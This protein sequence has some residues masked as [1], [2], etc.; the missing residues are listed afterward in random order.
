MGNESFFLASPKLPDEFEQYYQFRW[1]QLRKP[2]SF[3]LG[4]ERDAY[5][6]QAF[7]CMAIT[8]E[9][10]IIGIGRIHFDTKQSA[11]IRYMATCSQ[12]Q[13]RGVGSAIL[14]RLVDYAIEHGATR[15]WL[16]A[17]DQAVHFYT[18]N[19]FHSRGQIDSILPVRH[20]YMEKIVA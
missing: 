18:A 7:H 6:T 1:E 20:L 8:R 15:C 14:K 2:L 16:K 19:G 9:N 13:R 17:R 12:F 4:S 11:R 5:E 10:K 3:P